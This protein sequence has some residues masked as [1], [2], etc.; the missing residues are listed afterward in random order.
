[1]AERGKITV[2]R[3]ASGVIIRVEG[4]GTMSESPVLHAF[5]EEVLRDRGQQ[6]IVELAAC[7][8]MDS[9]FLGGL[10]GLFKR[11]GVGGGNRFAIFAPEPRRRSLFGVSRL[12]TILPFVDEVPVSAEEGMPLEAE[13]LTSR[14]ELAR[15][16]VEC[17]RRLAE[18]GGPEAQD[19]ARVAD[20]IAAEVDI[21]RRR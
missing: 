9:T 6:V 21:E 5:A 7:T 10:V 8:Y 3:F 11:Y 20:A 14:D 1:M 17:H 19:F 16:I 18:I 4:S 12:D 15:Y 13:A 2:V